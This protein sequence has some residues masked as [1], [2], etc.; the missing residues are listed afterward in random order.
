MKKNSFMRSRISPPAY[1]L[2]E[3]D[4]LDPRLEARKREFS[5]QGGKPDYAAERLGNRMREALGLG[6][7]LPAIPE[8]EDF[9]VADVVH[10][11][12]GNSYTVRVYCV[13]PG[14]DYDPTVIARILEERKGWL[15]SN[16]AA[17][18]VRKRVP[19]IVFAVMPP[20]ARP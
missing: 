9:A 1:E 17:S 5:A 6:S 18:I 8:L 19:D 4:G 15:R 14:L 2:G 20:G 7:V 11:G 10:G 13:D 3:G 16:I 12:A